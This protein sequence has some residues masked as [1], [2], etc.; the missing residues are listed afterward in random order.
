MKRLMDL[1]RRKRGAGLEDEGAGDW[2]IVRAVNEGS[3]EAGIIRIKTRKPASPDIAT[4]TTAVTIQW[5]YSAPSLP[6]PD[7]NER[8][9][10]FERS[11]D[12]LTGENGYSELVQVRTGFGNK[13]WLFYS[14]DQGTFMESFKG[15]LHGHPAYPVTIEFHEDAGWDLWQQTLNDLRARGTQV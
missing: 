1:F 12:E 7:E 8:M 13:E 10:D 9:L 15:L 3:G 5:P 4:F 2:A 6:D 14:R 11:I